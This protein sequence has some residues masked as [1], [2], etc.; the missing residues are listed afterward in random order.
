M[1]RDR[2]PCSTSVRKRKPHGI[3]ARHNLRLAGSLNPLY[4]NVLVFSNR[5]VRL[6]ARLC[7]CGA[8]VVTAGDQSLYF[9]FL[10]EAPGVGQYWR[11]HDNSCGYLSLV[12]FTCRVSIFRIKP[13]RTAESTLW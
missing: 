1:D 5:Q 10:V 3:W 7:N 11:N 12:R 8:A 6:I 4:T 2:P 13:S 9:P